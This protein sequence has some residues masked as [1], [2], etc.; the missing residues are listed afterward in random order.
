MCEDHFLPTSFTTD[1]KRL[2]RD[3][4]PKPYVPEE[5]SL[6]VLK[7]P[8][9]TYKR[10]REDDSQPSTSQETPRKTA[11][12]ND[13]SE[14]EA[15]VTPTTKQFLEDVAELP[16]PV[17][18]RKRKLFEID[19]HDTPIKRKLK[20]IVKKQR[21]QLTAKRT[22]ISRLRRKLNI[23][24]ASSSLQ[25]VLAS[26]TY[27][28]LYSKAIVNMQLL[29][30]RRS[31]W[32]KTEKELA[33]GLYYKS[34]SAYRYLLNL[35]IV[36]PALSTIRGWIS[37][38]KFLPGISAKLFKQISMKVKNMTADEK[39][40]ILCY[41]EMSIRKYLE[42]SKIIDQIEGFEDSGVFGR[43]T[44]FGKEALVFMVRGLY[45]RWKLPV[46]YFISGSATHAEKLKNIIL[47]NIAELRKRVLW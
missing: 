27:S 7:K 32:L 10:R 39:V 4:V 45:S 29:H 17:V 19:E 34:P 6:Y 46:S 47:L 14:N 35:N 33:L 20:G 28:S 15:A 12:V 1:G 38:S 16:T 2:K 37:C 42:Y 43:S 36:L 40:C 26:A 25:N 31:K 13:S 44:K 8:T 41:D 23:T 22:G 9:K 21:V 30:K 24:I 5:V 11:L 3:A 18:M